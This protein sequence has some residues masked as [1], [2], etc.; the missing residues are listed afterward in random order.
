MDVDETAKAIK[1]MRIRGAGRIARA[2]A[3]ALYDFADSY[4]GTDRERLLEDLEKAKRKLIASRPTAVSLYNGVTA[5]VKGA[6]KGADTEEIISIVKGHAEEFIENS[7]DAVKSIAE[8]GSSIIRDG[9]VL[10]THC[11]SS[12]AV[13]VIKEA[14]RQGKKIKVFATETRPWRQGLIT[15]RELY[16]VGIDVTL[17][18]DSAARLVMEGVN[19]VFVGADTVTAQGTLINKVGTS[20]LALAAHER[21]IPFYACAETYKFSPLTLKGDNVRIEVRNTDEVARPG[22][23]P[24]GV[25][26]YNPVFDR[27]PGELITY[28]ITESG[29][30]SPSSAKETITELFEEE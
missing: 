28:Y 24:E 29:M 7:R 25:K 4:E 10:M 3:S 14:H 6:E 11:N 21:N 20:Q 18:V 30:I 23:V 2:C 16:D 5:S 19:K 17:I 26:I 22:E 8:L 15:V 13:A 1:D 9:D 12:A 27:T